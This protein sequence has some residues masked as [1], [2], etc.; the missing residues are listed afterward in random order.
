MSVAI[1]GGP[2]SGKTAL[3]LE[4]YR[5]AARE[6]NALL[7][8]PTSFALA[9]LR[10]RL[11]GE[12]GTTF[13]ALAAELTGATLID[14]I[15][16]E[17]FFERAARP[18]LDL[19]WPE[20]ASGAIDPEVAGMRMPRRFLEA[21]FRL[22][23]RLRENGI[24][25]ETFL[26]TSQV[27]ATQ[28]YAHPPNL[29]HSDLL[30]YTKDTH[31]DSLAA[32]GAELQ[33]QFRNEAHLTKILARLYDA[34]VALQER[35]G[36]MAGR[37]AIVEATAAV[38]ADPALRARW[39]AVFV[40]E[41]QDL[42][43]GELGLL[44]ALRGERLEGVTLAGDPAGATG[45]FR[46]A[47][48]D[49]TFAATAERIELDGAR[50]RPP[51][52]QIYRARD[53]RTEAAYVADHVDE[54]IRGG[55]APDEIAVLFRSVRHVRAFEE[56]LLARG[57]PAVTVGDANVFA[58]PRALDAL[59]LLWNVYDPFRH[60]YMLRTLA[61]P[62]LALSDSSLA[63][64]CGEPETQTLLFAEDDAAPLTRSKRWDPRRDLRLGW[65]VVR[66]EAD[67]S[68]SPLARERVQLFRALRAGWVETSQR[69]AVADLARM[70]WSEGLARTGA[71]DSAT[72]RAQATVLR[73]LLHRIGEHAATNP[74]ADLG[75]F[76]R[77]AELRAAS[78]F[79]SC[80]EVS[81]SG[82]VRLMSIE[83]AR[84]LT[85][86]RVVVPAAKA[87]SFPRWYVPDAFLYSPTYGVVAKDNVG[88][89]VAART[90]KFSYY[91][92]R[93]KARERYNEEE[94][95]AFAYALTR[96]TKSALVT[97]SDRA[98]RG[99]TAPE[100]LEELRAQRL[101]GTEDL[102]GR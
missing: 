12:D 24:S 43:L 19:A 85:F 9:A 99:I 35:E 13:S 48:P 79:E 72:A 20:F 58:D 23:R 94:R 6:G 22:V 7:L 56:A 77:D 89:A 71:P 17:T 63:L 16:A 60:D 38:R 45:T 92:Y 21:A 95:R 96:A 36:V 29:T 32:E 28:F 49:R 30:M 87:G 47:R 98:T 65:N 74:G 83:A 40:D 93:T 51:L 46:G 64:L 75:D 25:P 5:E 70:V 18:L 84:G 69:I 78:E 14:D 55:T 27:G 39:D 41:A 59:A 33:R 90:A 4:R 8:A 50:G 42:N 52:V 37:D 26:Q 80:E 31:R 86:E 15:A 2:G 10:R 44:Q 91:I 11:G 61:G 34:Y 57:V 82:F 68:L 76:L 66:G 100:F 53:R 81:E 88:E 3:L 101:P 62:A 73:R 54:M 102:T 97:A 67:A 1:T